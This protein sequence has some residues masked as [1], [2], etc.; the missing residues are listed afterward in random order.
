[1][2]MDEQQPTEPVVIPTPAPVVV[3]KD[4]P[5]IVLVT[6]FFSWLTALILA[7]SVLVALINVGSERNDLRNQVESLSD[8]LNCRAANTFLVTRASA[9]KQIAL[10]QEMVHIG[11]FINL[12]IDVQT[13]VVSIEDARAKAPAIRDSIEEGKARLNEAAINL[14]NAVAQ[15]DRALESCEQ[16]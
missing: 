14:E 3:K 6:K 2:S 4:E 1:M 7:V 8:T 5:I 16:G 10:A 9:D 13:G 12:Y 15:V 11:D